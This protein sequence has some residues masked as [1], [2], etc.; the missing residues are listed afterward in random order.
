[1]IW[2]DF[3]DRLLP[4]ADRE[5]EGSPVPPDRAPTSE[6]N[7]PDPI[8]ADPARGGIADRRYQPGMKILQGFHRIHQAVPRHLATG[9]A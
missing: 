8:R 1:M 7:D 6:G 4:M 2:S 9:A 5:V 3:F